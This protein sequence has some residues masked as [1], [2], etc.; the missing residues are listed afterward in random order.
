MMSSSTGAGVT[1]D[2]LAGS[3]GSGRS[4]LGGRWLSAGI[5]S[6]LIAAVIGVATGPVPIPIWQVVLELLD[7]LPLIDVDSSL[8]PADRAIVWD[9]RAPRVVLGLLV[10]PQILHHQDGLA[11][12]GPTVVEV[13]AHDLGFFPK[14]SRPDA[15]YESSVRQPV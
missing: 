2:R 15:K 1:G 7:R 3:T 10:S 9:L 11:H 6:V 4:R 12:L 8:S 5:A 13:A 14:P